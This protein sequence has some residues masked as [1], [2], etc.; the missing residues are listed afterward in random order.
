MADRHYDFGGVH[1]PV[2]AGD[3]VQYNAGRD[4]YVAHGSQYNAGRDQYVAG[5]PAEMLAEIAALRQA[6]SDLRLTAHERDAAERDLGAAEE[7]LRHDEHPVLRP[8]L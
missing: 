3:G 2:Q 7:A 1:G 6:L 5:G 4:Q 8:H